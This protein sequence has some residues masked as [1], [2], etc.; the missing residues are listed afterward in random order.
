M[1]AMQIMKTLR[2]MKAARVRCALPL[3]TAARRERL[4]NWLALLA[5]L[6][7]SILVAPS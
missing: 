5:L 3:L 7:G 6:A 2:V 4:A 1:E